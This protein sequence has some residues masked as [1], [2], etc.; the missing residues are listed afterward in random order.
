[1][2]DTQ[3]SLLLVFRHSPYGSGLARAGVDFALACG[4]FE[5]NITLLFTGAGVLQLQGQQAAGALG[6]KDI[7]KQLASLPLYDIESVYVDAEA[8]ARYGVTLDDA[9]VPAQPVDAAAIR[10]MIDNHAH[11]ISL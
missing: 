4:A 7:G 9:P 3:K 2:G 10:A 6:L 5:Q 11:V 8:S 1:M